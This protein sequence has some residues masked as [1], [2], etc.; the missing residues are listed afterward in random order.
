[1]A[2]GKIWQ[3]HKVYLCQSPYF[4]SMFNGSWRETNSKFV[5]IE[6]L[7]PKIDINGKILQI[8]SFIF[9]SH[10]N[11]FLLLFLFAAL[12][13]VFGSLY[14]DEVT[15]DPKTVVSVLA[16]A[17]L[18][19]LDGLIDRCA[20]VM[21]ETVNAESTISYYEA[22]CQYGVQSVKQ[23]TFKWL[24]VNLLSYYSKHS[25][26]LSHISTDLMAELVNSADLFVV[27]TE[28]SLYMLLRFWLFLKLHPNYEITEPKP[29]H[30]KYFSSQSEGN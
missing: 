9:K 20:E 29:E 28:F 18:F 5:N 25:K 1:M 13:A 8:I 21:T 2:L 17:T 26:W 7:D 22:A 30:V 6:I 12:E 11:E 19:Q 10:H 16:T 14:I 3:L 27:Q 4:A 24:E 15:I 23:S